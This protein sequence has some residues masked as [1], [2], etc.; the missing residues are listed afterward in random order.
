MTIKYRPYQIQS[1]EMPFNYMANNPGNPCLELPTGSGKSIIVAGI[2][3]KVM[4]NWPDSKILML[5][6]Q[7][8]LIEQNAEKMRLIWPGAP[9][10]IYSAS[11]GKRQLSEPITFAG[12][13]SIVNKK[14]LLGK[15]DLIIVDECDLINNKQQGSYRILIDYLKTHNKHMRII[16]L[17]ATP[18]RLGQ[19]MITDGDDA[20][21]NDILKPVTI[22]ELIEQGYLAP[23]RSKL[24]DTKMDFSGVS[25]RGGDYSEKEKNEAAEKCD[26]ELIV[27]EAIALAG[28]R[29]AWLFFCAG[30]DH[31]A[32]IKDLLISKGIAA[33]I[34]T[35]KTPKKERERILAEYKAGK[36]RALTNA[37]VLTTGFDYPNIDMI[38]FLSPTLSA[39]KYV[40]MAG[41]GMRLKSHTDHCLVLDFAGLIKKHGPVTDITKPQ[42]SKKGEAPIK[43]CEQCHEI[44][45]L[46]AQFCSCCGFQFYELDQSRPIM[47]LDKQSCIMGLDKIKTKHINTWHW[48]E[49]I[50]A[51]T[52]NAMIKVTYYE[53][54]NCRGVTEYFPVLNNSER[55][56][57]AVQNIY[58]IAEKSGANINCSSLLDLA[59]ALNKSKPPSY[60]KYESKGKLSTVYSRAWDER[61]E[62]TNNRMAG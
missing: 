51:K 54:L 55:G 42:Q 62:N 15:V 33:D 35:G 25:V 5:T 40:Q 57:K 3:K 19:G 29:K 24:T 27:D 37:N 49:H 48:S 46:S 34:V 17:T 32:M 21:F 4:D 41:R 2:C 60:I 20:I 39:R 18:Y 45:H 23:L 47:E 52:G 58:N 1:I 43:I 28:D 14:D 59:E 13:Q 16:G 7:K 36:I 30:V 31:A 50:S 10:G 6:H 22:H 44:L 26:N 12:I 9:M 56:A 8:E 53:G 61:Q 38:S 11:V